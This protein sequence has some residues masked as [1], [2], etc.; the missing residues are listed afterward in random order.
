MFRHMLDVGTMLHL[1]YLLVKRPVFCKKKNI[2][3][4][5]VLY[6]ELG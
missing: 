1:F 3:H 4:A 6:E 5:I 2:K